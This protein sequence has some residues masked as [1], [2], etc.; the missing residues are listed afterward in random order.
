[1]CLLSWVKIAESCKLAVGQQ[2]QGVT[3]ANPRSTLHNHTREPLEAS[4]CRLSE[5]VVCIVG[6]YV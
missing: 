4:E 2:Q 3:A 5:V 6:E 1:M